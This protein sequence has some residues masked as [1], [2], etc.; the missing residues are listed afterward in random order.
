MSTK[1][2]APQECINLMQFGSPMSGE[3]KYIPNVGRNSFCE[4]IHHDNMEYPK[5]TK[6]VF[7]CPYTIVFWSDGT[8]TVVKTSEEDDFDETTGVLRAIAKKVF[9]SSSG[10]QKFI[11]REIAIDTEMKINKMIKKSIKIFKEEMQK[12]EV[13]N[14][15]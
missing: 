7:N 9:G 3:I 2:I 8:K 15:G 14:N 10:F 13:E 1:R 12:Q 11:N 5:P 6:V 4:F